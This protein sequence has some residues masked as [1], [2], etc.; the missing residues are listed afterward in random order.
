FRSDGVNAG[1]LANGANISTNRW[2][3]TNTATYT[4]DIERD[5]HFNILFGTEANYKK[6]SYWGTQRTNIFDDKYEELEGPFLNATAGGDIK[7]NTMMSYFGRINYDFAYKYILSLNYRRDG[8]SALGTPNR[9]GGFGGFSAA[10]R[11][12]EEPFF[13]SI[14]DKIEDF[15]IK[16][17]YG[18]VGNTNIDDYASKTYYR[19]YYYGTSGAYHLRQI[20]DPNLKWE[21]STKYDVGFN[22]SFLERFT[23]DF[24]YYFTKSKD[25]ILEVPQA[26][27]RGI[28]E[29]VYITNAGTME[30]SGIE[31]TLSADIF[32][33]GDF[34]W[35]TSFNITTNKNKVTALAEGLSEILG[36]DDS[37][38]EV[39]NKTVVGKSLGQLYL[40]PTGGVDPET[41]RRIFYGSKGEKTYF[42]Y[43]EGDWF[44]ED[45]KPFEGEFEQ[46]LSGNTLP[47]WYGG[48]SN[49][50]SYKN[51]DLSVFFQ[52]SGGNKIYNGTKATVSDMRYWNNSKDVWNKYWTP[53][54]KNAE[55][56]LPIYGDNYSNGSAMPISD[57]MEKGDYL[58]LKNI[59]LGYTFDTRNW[60]SKLGISSLRLYMQA[61]NLFVITSYSGLDPETLTNVM[62]ANLSGGT[63]KNTLPQARTY[64]FGLNV[65]F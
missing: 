21:S 6:W 46:V 18:I 57:W 14:K 36:M 24:D 56:P 37:Q 27:S 42:K 59:S 9:W 34:K 16:G 33:S 2:T 63:D 5:H 40:F 31:M 62:D 20:G 8:Y 47:T 65:S 44:T 60:S 48:W 28:P 13:E 54:R 15:K 22:M 52:F 35:T 3:W 23:L 43:E 51:F 61:Q 1:G 64:T 4:F 12:S 55:Y 19:T 7:K 29:G 26:P 50:F 53:E 49:N 45:G 39:T 58:R 41:G 32:K 25:L 38:L 10:W 30:N 11:V 17:S